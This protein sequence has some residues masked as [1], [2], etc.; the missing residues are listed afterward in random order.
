MHDKEGALKGPDVIRFLRHLLRKIPG[1]L[2]VVWDGSPIHR[3]KAVKE[4]LAEGAAERG[5]NSNDCPATLPS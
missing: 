5:C 2:L 4:F 1:K 3:S